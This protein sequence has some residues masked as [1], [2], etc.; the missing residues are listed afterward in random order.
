M[1]RMKRIDQETG[2]VLLIDVYATKR[3]YN[4]RKV[5]N[6]SEAERLLKNRKQREYLERKKQELKLAGI[7]PLKETRTRTVLCVSVMAIHIP[8]KEGELK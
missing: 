8:N 4:N 1:K 7:S 6:M 5:S 2:E 3:P